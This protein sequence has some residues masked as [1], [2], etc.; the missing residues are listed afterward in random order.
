MSGAAHHAEDAV[1]RP[2]ANPWLIA[3]VVTIAAFME[4]LD[5][6]IVNVS[7]PHIAGSVSASY[8]DA[9]WT[10]TSYLVA[11]GIV[12]PISGFIGRV[13]GRKRYFLICIAGFVVCSFLCGTA[14]SLGQMVVFRLMQ[15]FFGG[16]LQ[17]NQQAIIL[18]TFEPKKRGA[19]FGVVAIAVIFA[20]AIGP[21]LG[22][23]LTDSYSWRWI[24]WINI[25]VGLIAFFAVMTLVEDPP[26]VKR[27]K[28]RFGDTDWIGLTLI[29]LGI[30]C[31]QVMM[32]RGEDEDWFSSGFI[33]MMAAFAVV[34]IIGAIV[35]LTTTDKPIVRLSVFKDRNF[36]VGTVMI[37]GV[38][39]VLY[40]GAVLVP[41]LAQQQLGYTA[42]LAGL[43]LSPGA[44]AIVVLIPLVGKFLMPN[45]Q[46]RLIIAF[47][48]LLI[49]LSY[50][51]S[52]LIV[53]PT[54]NFGSLVVARIFQVLG[55]AFLFVPVSTIAYTTLPRSLN[56]DASSLFVMLRNIAGSIGISL[57]TAGVTERTQTHMAYLQHY[58]T[59]LW[60]PYNE[61][62]QQLRGALTSLGYVSGQISQMLP[63]QINEMFIKQASMLAYRDLF[64]YCGVAAFCVIPLA[65]LFSPTKGGGRGGGGH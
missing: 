53:V 29:A 9:T 23:F 45:V 62:Q 52:S 20:P 14:T 5:T 25:P 11:N 8:D 33:V 1:W 22:G 48:F 27:D 4:I 28:A 41:Q 30:G 26:W 49:G 46:T 21:T 65:F 6:T 50:F 61:L 38:G 42:T 60:A 57:A 43:I 7:L 10:L 2:K 13:I 24:F 36:A 35:W 3:V 16:G 12:L 44:I 39:A 15:G 31:L 56:N 18:D 40:S 58:M 54:I 64:V 47:G 59:P 51:Y 55:L 63:A 37:T 19:A 34:G 32:D 17:P